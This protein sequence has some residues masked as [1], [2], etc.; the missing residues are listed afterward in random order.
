MLTPDE[1]S[2]ADER[3]AK[4]N[5]HINRLIWQWR[6]NSYVHN[7]KDGTC[8]VRTDRTELVVNQ[9]NYLRAVQDLEMIASAAIVALSKATPAAEPPHL[10]VANDERAGK[11]SCGEIFSTFEDWQTHANGGLKIEQWQQ[12]WLNKAG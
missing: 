12:D 5:D 4:A 1:L 11:C 10:Y 6:M 3:L 2:A 7:C 8:G 9:A